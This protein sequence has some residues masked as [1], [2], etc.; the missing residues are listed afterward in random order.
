M[1]PQYPAAAQ[2]KFLHN[3][4]GL[5]IHIP[6][7]EKRCAYC[8]FYSAFLSEEMLDKYM[9]ALHREIIKWGGTL[10]RPIDTIYIGGGTP[11]LL[12]ER[13]VPLMKCI[14]ENFD[15]SEDAEITAEV[16]PGKSAEVFLK[17]AK[18]AGVNRISIGAQSGDNGMLKVLGRTHT[19][20]DTARAVSLAR[21][22]G[23]LNISL[24][25]MIG[26]PQS[27]KESLGRDIDFIKKL[28]PE[29]I[30]A[31]ILKLESDT[32]FGKKCEELGLPDDE[33]VAEQYLYMCESLESAGFEHYEIS[34][35]SK[36]GYQSRHNL[37]YWLDQQYLGIGPAAHSFIDNRRF[38]NTESID[39]YVHC[40]LSGKVAEVFS[41][42]VVG[43][44]A[45]SEFTMLAL[46]TVN[47]LDKNLYQKA[48]NS[49]FEND[50][51]FAIKKNSKYLDISENFIKIKK[52]YLYVQN[53]ILVDFISER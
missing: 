48:F 47:G 3:S 33:G 19:A 34:N 52:E 42:E 37:K 13:I 12:G 31:Y 35:F 24:D 36:P 10:D 25:L 7:C 53:S 1:P 4:A 21:A 40:I 14:Y 8:D 39:E 28:E 51:A 11:S 15:I 2:V 26:L 20:E 29:H 32:A 30:S 17:C 27:T 43:D 38:T 16:N 9:Q 44:D 6:F 45:K 5:Y 18:Q 46:R 23:F 22:A 41:E 50:F 49:N